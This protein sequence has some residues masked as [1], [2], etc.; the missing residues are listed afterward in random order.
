MKTF[1][2][3]TASSVVLTL[4]LATPVV[5]AE[6]QRGQSATGAQT[7]SRIG[8]QAGSQ[9]GSQTSWQMGQSVDVSDL[10]GKQLLK[11]VGE[12]DEIVR[13]KDGDK[14]FVVVSLEDGD[15]QVAIPLDKLEMRGNTLTAP[16]SAS[17]KDDLASQSE[18]KQ[19]DYQQV[20]AGQRIDRSEFAAFESQDGTGQ[21]SLQQDR[22]M[23][24][25]RDMQ[26]GG[27][28]Q[29]GGGSQREGSPSGTRY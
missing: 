9:T 24:Q 6:Q 3:V 25:G 16:K 18:Y 4:M 14:H 5:V 22:G 28:M 11:E 27:S 19:D 2:A 20:N 21:G 26:E 8:S 1:N 29:Q 23:Q 15:K 7:G 10:K 17:S 12:I 13:A